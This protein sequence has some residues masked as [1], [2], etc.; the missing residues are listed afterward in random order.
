V[1]FCLAEEGRAVAE[2]PHP[3]DMEQAV[4]VINKVIKRLNMEI[5]C[6]QDEIS[7][8]KYYLFINTVENH[9]SR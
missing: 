7:S 4:S 8:Q 5:R 9:I 1:L 3:K 6:A 2:N